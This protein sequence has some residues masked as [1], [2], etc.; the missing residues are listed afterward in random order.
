MAGCSPYPVLTF[1]ITMYD[2]GNPNN[3]PDWD[4][5]Y[6]CVTVDMPPRGNFVLGAG[7]TPKEAKDKAMSNV[8]TLGH[9]RLRTN[10][11]EQHMLR[12]GE[13]EPYYGM[14]VPSTAKSTR[15]NKYFLRPCEAK[16]YIYGEDLGYEGMCYQMCTK[17][18]NFALYTYKF[19]TYY[20][21]IRQDEC[22][23]Q[24]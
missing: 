8:L 14:M 22:S 17:I 20:E 15:Y 10:P 9:G 12:I 23:I 7:V 16:I 2:D 1:L 11:Y 21:G 13:L 6:Y 5:V 4:A 18:A 19:N 24:I 3:N